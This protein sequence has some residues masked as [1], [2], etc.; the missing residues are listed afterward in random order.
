MYTRF[1]LEMDF[2]TSQRN[3]SASIQKQCN[4]LDF[5]IETKIK[6]I[7]VWCEDRFIRNHYPTQWAKL[8]ILM[9]LAQAKAKAD[10][11][12]NKKFTRKKYK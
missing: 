10:I 11:E 12:L 7:G 8:K 5:H 1:D 6:R 4:N 3:I 9:C 2:E